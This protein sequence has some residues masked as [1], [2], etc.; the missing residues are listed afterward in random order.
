M[1]R[2]ASYPE[3]LNEVVKLPTLRSRVRLISAPTSPSRSPMN[4]TDDGDG[5][6]NVDDVGLAHEKLLCLLANLA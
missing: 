6:G 3:D 4:V 1:R 5:R 2:V